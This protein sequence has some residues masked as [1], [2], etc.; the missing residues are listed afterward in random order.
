MK[1]A[2]LHGYLLHGS[3]SNIYVQNVTRELVNLGHEVYLFCQ[4][5]H[6][7]NYPFIKKAYKVKNGKVE[8]YFTRDSKFGAILVNPE[9]DL[10]PVYVMDKYP[11]F[12]E[13]KL[14]IE[15]SQEELKEYINRNVNAMSLF[16]DDVKFDIIHAN[17]LV[18]MPYIASLLSEKYH[19]PFVITPHGSSLEYTI[20]KDSR[21]LKYAVKGLTKASFV[22][23]GNENFQNR[24]INFF[25]EK[26]YNL[27][28]K[29]RIVP[30]GVNTKLFA[31]APIGQRYKVLSELIEKL[32]T[33]K[34][35]KTKTDEM[36]FL[37][38]IQTASKDKID[39]ILRNV[40]QYSQRKP[41]ES[42]PEK[43]ERLD[44]ERDRIVAFVGRLIPGK[45]IH[46]FLFAIMPLLPKY[47][48]L[49][50]IIAGAGPMREWGEWIV[51]AGS[52][53]DADLLKSLIDWGVKNF[54]TEKWLWNSLIAYF[55][56]NTH[57]IEN[58]TFDCNRVIFTGFIEHKYLAP[59]LA[60][61]EIACFP[62]LVPESFGL[63][64]LEAASAG[65][66]PIASYFSGFKSILNSFK[67]V[68]PE[69]NFELLTLPI[70]GPEVIPTMTNKISILLKERP[71]I[72]MKLR[73]LVVKE[74][75]WESVTR[76]LE[77]VYNDVLANAK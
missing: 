53:G 8:E 61:T 76:K 77:C 26:V 44:P 2:M 49:K 64:L 30:L 74:F 28:E 22:L 41:D 45:G 31:P 23:P 62:S 19:V 36:N 50:V 29:M 1:I 24:L 39:E 33:E 48:D 16:F 4:E 9:L 71:D 25:K 11:E 72:R 20:Q 13:V 63:V 3:G 54:D 69:Q 42:L 75:S 57:Q 46:N 47:N 58:I 5:R 65:A 73:E 27:K 18:M 6:P 12:K 52:K 66:I 43:L 55:E 10:L 15:L 60:F 59:L 56:N 7:E 35:G 34:G 17:H 70:S 21:Y 38:Q 40:P 68:L 37:R 51:Y 32:K 67:E 14:F